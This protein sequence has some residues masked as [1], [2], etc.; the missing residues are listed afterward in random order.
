MISKSYKVKYGNQMQLGN[1]LLA[2]RLLVQEIA[3]FAN[4]S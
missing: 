3:S 4:K 1:I 2:G